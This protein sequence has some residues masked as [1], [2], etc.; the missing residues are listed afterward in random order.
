M[1][2]ALCCGD[3]LNY[4]KDW[5]GFDV[6]RT[7]FP[8]QLVLGDVRTLDGYRFRHAEGIFATPPCTEFS[9]ARV[10]WHE[11]GPPDLS[12]VEA[13]LRIGDE[14][15]VPFI[16]ENV[17]GLQQL[18]GPST[19]HRGPWHFWGDVGLLPI[20]KW[21]KH[22]ENRVRD[23]RKRATVPAPLVPYTSAP[24]SRNGEP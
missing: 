3:G 1:K 18:I 13:C 19:A 23:P 8:G 20:G 12:V 7:R 6:V 2:I 14:A 10:V 9:L 11:I 21:W 24:P 17:A 4:G 5:I 22:V 16:M 15:G